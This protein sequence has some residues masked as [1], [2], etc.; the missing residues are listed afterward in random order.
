MLGLCRRRDSLKR[1][2]NNS[3]LLTRARRGAAP[4]SGSPSVGARQ[5]RYDGN[6]GL[7]T[8]AHLAMPVLRPV[9]RTPPLRG[10]SLPDARLPRR[11]RL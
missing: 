2:Q 11:P 1:P 5:E 9:Q 10:A 4:A 3:I 6:H 8:H 7:A